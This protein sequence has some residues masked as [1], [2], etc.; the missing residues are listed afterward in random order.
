MKKHF[1]LCNLMFLI[2]ISTLPILTGCSIH[3]F[4]NGDEKPGVAYVSINDFGDIESNAKAFG[5]TDDLLSD[6][7]KDKLLETKKLTPQELAELLQQLDGITKKNTLFIWGADYNGAMIN[8][9]GKTCIQAASYARSTDSTLDISASLLK[10]LKGINLDNDDDKLIALRITESIT[11]LQANSQQSTYL[12]AGLFGICILHA[13]GAL[14]ND[15]ALK[16]INNLIKASE[17]KVPKI[18]VNNS[19]KNSDNNDS[20]DMKSAKMKSQETIP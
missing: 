8:D 14:K 5:Y 1:F 9:T 15:E 18:E 6:T 16:A 19:E 7:V 10:V 2:S 3:E 4:W 12:S 13:N 17:F 20:K 11:S